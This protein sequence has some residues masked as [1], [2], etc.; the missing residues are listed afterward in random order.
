[1]F[2]VN[3]H[4]KGLN[5]PIER[6]FKTLARADGFALD[7]SN[8]G[9]WINVNSTDKTFYPLSRIEQINMTESNWMEDFQKAATALGRVSQSPRS[10]LTPGNRGVQ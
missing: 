5:K 6:K 2:I 8:K 4:I 3:V 1:M 7:V 9:I 10:E